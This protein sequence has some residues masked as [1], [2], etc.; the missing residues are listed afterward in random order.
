MEAKALIECPEETVETKWPKKENSCSTYME[1]WTGSYQNCEIVE[2]EKGERQGIFL[3]GLY[4]DAYTFCPSIK[5]LRMSFGCSCPWGIS[6]LYPA[7]RRTLTNQS[8]KMHGRSCPQWAG[9]RDNNA[10]NL[11][12]SPKRPPSLA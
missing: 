10:G 7:V 12:P 11:N 5:K 3:S 8:F 2:A 9:G 1:L 4:I 6:S